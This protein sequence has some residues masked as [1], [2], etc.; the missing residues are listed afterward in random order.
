MT[1][2]FYNPHDRSVVADKRIIYN[3]IAQYTDEG[4]KIFVNSTNTIAYS[5]CGELLS[6]E[7]C[8]IL[9]ILFKNW[10]YSQ[11][12]EDKLA[13]KNFFVEMKKDDH[14]YCFIIATK[15]EAYW[16]KYESDSK[17]WIFSKLKKDILFGF[18]S[19][20]EAFTVC[21]L[22]QITDNDRIIQ[23]VHLST[24][25]VSRNYDV[26][27]QKNLRKLPLKR[28]IINDSSTEEQI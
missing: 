6:E 18:G 16:M 5:Q 28:K 10:H 26:V 27:K 12:E 19:G 14:H 22:A 25:T 8:N 20:L 11:K 2:I 3:G 13:I 1:I 23:I 9:D 17:Y 15:E 21:Q 7:Q 4:N 24:T